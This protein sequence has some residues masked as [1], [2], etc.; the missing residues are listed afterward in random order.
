MAKDTM[1]GDGIRNDGT[2][3]GCLIETFYKPALRW[4]VPEHGQWVQIIMDDNGCELATRIS[5]ADV[6][7]MVALL[8]ERRA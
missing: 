2:V 3:K 4:S 8:A 1:H 6:H 7:A 5:A